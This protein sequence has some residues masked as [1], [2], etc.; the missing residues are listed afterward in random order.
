MLK[1]TVGRGHV[2]IVQ[3][4]VQALQVWLPGHLLK[5]QE[6]LDLRGKGETIVLEGVFA[7]IIDR[8]FTELR[9]EVES[10]RKADHNW[11]E[12]YDENHRLKAEVEQIRS[13]NMLLHYENQ[14]LKAEIDALKQG[15]NKWM[16]VSDALIN[17]IEAFNPENLKNWQGLRKELRQKL[18]RQEGEGDG[19]REREACIGA[20]L[21]AGYVDRLKEGEDDG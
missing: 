6:G 3:A 7:L 9:A 21:P 12:L 18:A 20:N 8:H 4:H 11:L 5:C 17:T 1:R 16:H 10:L 19:E 14:R 13:E 15:L 2:H